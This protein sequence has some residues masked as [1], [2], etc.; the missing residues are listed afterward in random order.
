MII[1]VIADSA[2]LDVGSLLLLF[3][4]GALLAHTV[5]E[6]TP[7][8]MAAGRSPVLTCKALVAVDTHALSIM[9]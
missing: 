5:R 1:K 4:E 8:Q 7:L 3:F 2:A 6:H 9:L